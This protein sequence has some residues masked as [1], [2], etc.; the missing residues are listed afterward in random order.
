MKKEE[1]I[2][3]EKKAFKDYINNTPLAE[4]TEY[5]AWHK[6]W[7][8]ALEQ[9]GL[10]SKIETYQYYVCEE[11]GTWRKPNVTHCPE[12]GHPNRKDTK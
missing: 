10:M 4:N 6:G 2:K 9:L 8:S 7:D 3:A 5:D 1:L 11:C 12:C